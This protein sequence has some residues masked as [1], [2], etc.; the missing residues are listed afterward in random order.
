MSFDSDVAALIQSL[1]TV[2]RQ[3]DD[4]I[5]KVGL[6]GRKS[7]DE[8]LQMYIDAVAL[9]SRWPKDVPALTAMLKD[10]IQGTAALPAKAAKKVLAQMQ[11]VTAN[12][13]KRA[14]KAKPDPGSY[15]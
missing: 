5:K 4:K 9:F 2:L 15:D 8:Q 7:D 14:G 12:A 10:V 1:E 13:R 11:P 6:T 3:Y